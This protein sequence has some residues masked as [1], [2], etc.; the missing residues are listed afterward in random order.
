MT[1]MDVLKEKEIS[2]YTLSKISG[3]P[4]ATVADICSGKTKIARCNA[5]TLS[6]LSQSLD[7]KI[8]DLLQL[9]QEKPNAHKEYFEKGI[10]QNLQEGIDALLKGRKDKVLYVDCLSDDLY[11]SINADFWAGNITEKQAN[12][13]REKYL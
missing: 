5:V 3:V 9:E 13:L 10:P 8:E 4:W 2:R 12:Y 1:I 11:G 7:M 6:K